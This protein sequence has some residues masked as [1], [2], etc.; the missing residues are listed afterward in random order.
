M[1]LKWLICWLAIVGIGLSACDREG[2][3][4]SAAEGQGEG[5]K[6]KG[7]SDQKGSGSD[8]EDEESGGYLDA[9]SD[10][11]DQAKNVSGLRSLKQAIQMFKATEGRLPKNLQEVV[12]EGYIR[13]LPDLPKGKRLSYDP[14]SGQVSVESE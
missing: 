14:A 11:M 1:Q 8:E 9:M 7:A 13:S 6:V 4:G 12:S 3:G 5:S 2:A 10:A